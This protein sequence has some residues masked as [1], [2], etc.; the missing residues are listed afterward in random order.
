MK[1]ICIPLAMVLGFLTI[2]VKAQT[3]VVT[4]PVRHI[5]VAPAPVMRVVI[6]PR[7]ALVRPAPVV[8]IATPPRRK[9]IVKKT[10]IYK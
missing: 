7:P 3:V 8:V 1:K 5:V 6:R 2:E 9:V 4:R 10:V